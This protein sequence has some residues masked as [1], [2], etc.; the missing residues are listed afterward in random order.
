ML[1]DRVVRVKIWTRDGRD[2]LLGRAAADR[3]H[4]PARRDRASRAADGQRRRRV[5]DLAAPR[6]ASSAAQGKLLEVYLPIRA[7]NGTPLLFETYQRY[8]SVAADAAAASGCRSPRLLLGAPRAALARPAAARVAARA[9]AAPQPGGA[10]G[11]ARPALEASDRERRRIAADLHDGVVQDLAGLSY[12]LAAAAAERTPS[13]AAARGDAFATR[14]TGTRD[15]D[16]PAALAARRDLPAE[17]PRGRARGGARRPRSRRS[18]ARASDVALDVG[19]RARPR[20]R[21]RGA[22]LPRGRGG[23]AQRRARTPAR[24]RGS[25][26]P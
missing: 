23:A 4:V 1:G 16:A 26:S 6:T 19:P 7:P 10:R 25:R 17:P 24:A 15:S 21:R 20:R 2:R 22:R 18:S 11:A 9:P 12:S 14:P 3:R 13:V 8:S 5:S